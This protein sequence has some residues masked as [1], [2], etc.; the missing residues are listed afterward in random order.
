[1]FIFNYFEQKLKNQEFQR[2]LRFSLV[3]LVGMGVNYFFLFIFY[4]KFNLYYLLSAAFAVEI[5]VISNFI[6]NNKW[7]FKDRRRPEN[8]FLRFLKFNLVSMGGI[9]IN[10]LTLFILKENFG[11]GL[12]FANFF[13]ILGAW[14][15]NFFVNNFWT[16]K[17]E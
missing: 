17:S 7:T 2:F 1:M 6:L 14:L 11:F 12:Y 4:E 5:S 13:A 15:W 9:G 8:I 16:W 10:L 3:G